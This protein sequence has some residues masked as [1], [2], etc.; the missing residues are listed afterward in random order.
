V[1]MQPIANTSCRPAV[2][3]ASIAGMC[4]YVHVCTSVNVYQCIY[5][6]V[7]VYVCMCVCVPVCM[8]ICVTPSPSS[9]AALL[10]AFIAGMCVC[11]YVST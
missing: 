11:Q 3:L 6:C 7:C 5:V 9:R 2:L 1:L 10:L 8:C 4:I